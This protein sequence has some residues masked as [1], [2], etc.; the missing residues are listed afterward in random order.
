MDK[1]E[2]RDVVLNAGY[3]IYDNTGHNY[4]DDYSIEQH[5]IERGYE[6]PPPNAI[7]QATSVPA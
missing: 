3:D 1:R 4:F 5:L 2:F 6:E 7:E